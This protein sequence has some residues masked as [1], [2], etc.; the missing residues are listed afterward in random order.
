MSRVRLAGWTSCM[1]KLLTLDITSKFF[2]HF[3]MPVKIMG[4]IDF[5]HFIPL[6][7][8]LTLP[9][10]TRSAQ[11]NIFWLYFLAC[12]STDQ[13]KIK[14]SAE[15]IEVERP[16]TSFGCHLMKQRKQLFYRL[17]QKCWH[18]FRLLSVNFNQTCY[19]DKD[20]LIIHGDI[21]LTMTFI[22]DHRSARAQKKKKKKKNKNPFATNDLTRTSINLS[23][24]RYPVG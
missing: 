9:G 10:V 8:T 7:L 16:D 12:F 22:Q 11:S 20:H 13:N 4:T 3:F 14:Y 15:A 6:S 18:A 1:H 19:D 17:R 5:L 21:C 23:G 24:I 2:N